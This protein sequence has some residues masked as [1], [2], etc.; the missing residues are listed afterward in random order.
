MGEP[1]PSKAAMILLGGFFFTLLLTNTAFA[2]TTLDVNPVTKKLDLITDSSSFGTMTGVSIT[3][4][5]TICTSY[6]NGGALTTDASG[7]VRCSDDDTGG[8]INTFQTWDT[9]SGTDIVADSSTDTATFT[10]SGLVVTGTAA[11]DS[12]DFAIDVQYSEL[13]GDVLATNAGVTTI[14]PNSV[15]LTT[16]TTGNYVASV[17]CAETIS[18]CNVATEGDTPTLGVKGSTLTASHFN[19]TNAGTAGQVLSLTGPGGNFTWITSSG[20]GDVTDVNEGLA[21][22]VTNPTGPAPTVAFDP[23]ELTG[24]R[25]WDDGATS[26]Q[27]TWTW[28]LSSGTDPTITFFDNR[29]T[30]TGSLV[31][32]TSLDGGSVAQILNTDASRAADTS[33]LKLADNAGPQDGQVI[34]LQAVGDADSTATTDFIM[35]QGGSVPLFFGI[36]TTTESVYAD[37][38]MAMVRTG[39][40]AELDLR[41]FGNTTNNLYAIRA[42]NTESVPTAN[43]DNDSIFEILGIS[44][45]GTNFGESAGIYF[46]VEGT[47]TAGSTPGRITLETA[48]PGTNVN[49]AVLMI[50]PDG[51]L[52]FGDFTLGMKFTQDDD[53]ALTIQGVGDGSQESLTLN[54]DDTSNKGIYTSSTGLTNLSY[55]GIGSTWSGILVANGN[56][57]VG[58]AAT[59]AA[60]VTLNEDTDNGA[61]WIAIQAPSAITSNVTCTL[62]DDSNPIPDSCVGDGTDGGGGGNSFETW[63]TPA[64]TAP[65]ADSATDTITFTA[66]GIVVTGTAGTDTIDFAPSS[67]FILPQ[68]A[69]CSN[70]ID[71]RTCWDTDGDFLVIGDGANAK[72]IPPISQNG[73]VTNSVAAYSNLFIVP[74]GTITAQVTVT[75]DWLVL[76]NS[77]DGV[78]IAKTVSE[79]CLITTSGIGGLEASDAE[80]S[81]TWYNIHIYAKEDGTV[82][83]L[84]N[85]AGTAVGTVPAGYVYSM[86]VGA[87]RNDSSSNFLEAYTQGD[88]VQYAVSVLVLSN[89]T[90]TAFTDIDASALAP[91]TS[92]WIYG[93]AYC[94]SNN[95]YFFL[96]RPNGS[97]A[98]G[99]FSMGFCNGSTDLGDFWTATDS[100][101]I[102][103]YK[104]DTVSNQTDVRFRGYKDNL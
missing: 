39:G 2:A 37:A 59:G 32:G 97:S 80:A 6:A 29:I 26:A 47:P 30:V 60:L 96:T 58:N 35:K 18:G 25:T 72:A 4:T 21:I 50:E 8:S 48:A 76:R 61:N 56:L 38:M 65:V 102:Y 19:T 7:N 24:N 51:S 62:E 63:T 85:S 82:D 53:G 101:Q 71:A 14:Q 49:R 91:P 3:L 83:C 42:R 98:A 95:L 44:N 73:T 100:A 40:S 81:S 89:G 43:A 36:G 79:T 31:V 46:Y 66:S 15:A 16:D 52:F 9:P 28:N 22:D 27:D 41:S 88:I 87:I 94:D 57:T 67:P 75:A 1:K 54:L 74:S 34:Y 11:S 86:R 69:S 70:T 10:V 20:S 77:N 17:S 55:N 93:D 12:I 45:D 68:A 90:A 23:T 5:G 78:F 84:L 33:L 103:E 99:Q 104:L 92:R 64:G 13:T